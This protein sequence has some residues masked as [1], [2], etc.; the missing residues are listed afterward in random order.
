M[1]FALTSPQISYF[2]KE[3]SG[4]HRVLTEG[5]YFVGRRL[6]FKF[7]IQCCNTVI[8]RLPGNQPAEEC[9]ATSDGIA[10][11]LFHISIRHKFKLALNRKNSSVV[12]TCLSSSWRNRDTTEAKSQF[13]INTLKK[14]APNITFLSPPPRYQII[15]FTKQRIIN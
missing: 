3:G 15:F 12:I 6:C 2:Q 9:E 7:L 14:I 4:K 8:H 11:A 13:L 1:L 5:K 10:R